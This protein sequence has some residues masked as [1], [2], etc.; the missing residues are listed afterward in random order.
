[1][2]K[3]DSFFIRAGLTGLTGG[4]FTTENVDLGAFVDALG[5]TVLRVHNIS[6]QYDFANG[7]SPE[8][9]LANTEGRVGWQLTTQDQ[10]ALV[11]AT[12]RSLV[13]SGHLDAA[14]A[15]AVA[16]TYTF[17]SQDLDVAPQEWT[18]GFLVAVESLQ[19]S[20]L[21]TGFV[22]P[23]NVSLVLECTS[24]TMTQAAAMALALSQQ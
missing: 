3:S 5:K 18:G 15:S 10:A 19:L 11:L 22:Q 7:G 13:S 8:I 6:V 20:G 4:V 1:M 2:A 16:N 9:V 17:V 12:N 14:N 21:A 23:C 24:E